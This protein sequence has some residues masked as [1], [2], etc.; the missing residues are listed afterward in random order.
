M[1]AGIGLNI[2][3]ALLTL[4]LWLVL[5]RLLLQLARADFY[6]PIS[7]GIVGATD[8]VLKPLRAVLPKTGSLDLA[9]LLM[10]VTIIIAPCVLLRMALGF[11]ALG[12][13]QL[14]AFVVINFVHAVL[15]IFLFCM[16]IVFVLSWV[17]PSS[18]H[19]GAVLA[20]QITEPLLAPV[21]RIIPAVGGL[22]LSFTVV[23]IVLYAVYQGI[24]GGTL[25]CAAP[26]LRDV[27]WKDYWQ[28]CANAATR[29]CRPVPT[30]PPTFS[31]TRS[32][33]IC[34]RRFSERGSRP[35]ARVHPLAAHLPPPVCAA[36]CAAAAIQS[37]VCGAP[38]KSDISR[39]RQTRR[40]K[41]GS[42]GK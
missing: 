6:N 38:R 40:D 29:S 9:A 41:T 12:V 19:P 16:F 31:S 34:W 7:Q 25:L 33:R 35:R 1:L 21:R 17:A 42:A 39:S 14:V 15:T 3:D 13:V 30:P 36:H 27:S 26:A 24:G 18:Y 22:D 2:L 37:D 28:S 20:R 8:T 10:A 23:I 32:I 5:V 4:A 11:P